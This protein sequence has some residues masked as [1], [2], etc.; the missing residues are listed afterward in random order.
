MEYFVTMK[1]N[2][3]RTIRIK[4]K[5]ICDVYSEEM[6]YGPFESKKKAREF[7]TNYVD[8]FFAK[9]EDKYEK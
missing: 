3:P 4:R 8:G 6:S 7:I 5:D 9:K 1:D 2:D